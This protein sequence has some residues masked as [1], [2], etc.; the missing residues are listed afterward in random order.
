MN[1]PSRPTRVV[2]A[3][4]GTAG[5]L[6]ATALVRQLGP[7]V[8]VT[9]V[10]S[11]EIGTVGVGESTIPTAR[12]FHAFLGIDEAAFMKATQAT[13]KLGIAFEN[14][15]RIG[16]R[17][18]HPFGTVG[19]SVA[20]ADFQH[21]WLEARR[22]GFGGAY[23]DHSLE[24]RA[25]AEG[26]FARTE[27]ETLAYA[28]HLDATAYARFLRAIAEPAG[29]RRVEGRITDVE[30]NGDSGAI[31]ALH[32]AAGDRIAGDLFLDCTGFRALLA[33]GALATGFEDWSEWLACDR[34]L[35]VQTE[36]VR[37]PVPYTRA[38]AHE[39]GWRWQ[40]PLQTRLGNGLVYA[41]A[42]MS[43]DEAMAT[44]L[45]GIEGRPLFDPRPLRFRAGMR[46]QA[47]NRN[48]VALGLAA[49]FIEPLE[50]TSIHL[51]M[52]AV[53][54]LIQCFP[55]QG[56]ESGALAARF[57][58]QSRHEWEHIR[59]FII[60]HYVQTERADSPFW[61]R[62]AAMRVPDSLAHRIALFA[63]SAGAWQGQDD[64]FRVD[65][66]VSVMLGQGLMP[67]A[68]HRIARMLSEQALRESLEGLD[69]QLTQQLRAIPPHAEFLQ[70]Y[71]A[72]GT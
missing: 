64:L 39:A 56:N 15:H 63:E 50:S 1:D 14:W 5:W 12:S 52:I 8:E 58:A 41:S 4:G 21:F 16:A 13:F 3:G 29:V 28:Y 71:C 18:F 17:Y 24:A 57:N 35:A 45:N 19:R 22:H 33:E 40:I 2:I 23:T 7:L 60:L 32:L 72:A 37:P 54:R 55:F 36:A 49:G 66:W 53:M 62:C 38:I 59:D 48:C 65:S 20:I 31:A 11:D 34:A 9:L 51:V 25:A 26:R 47:W 46:R 61:R 68:Y 27:A 30:R 43:D 69:R 44:L 6:A 10:E 70:R 42:H 67:R